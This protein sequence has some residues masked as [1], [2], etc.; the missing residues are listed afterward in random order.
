MGLVDRLDALDQR[1]L[2]ILRVPRLA[3]WIR[4]HP[5]ATLGIFVASGYSP[6]V[7]RALP[8]ASWLGAVSSV[9]LLLGLLWLVAAAI[10][11]VHDMNDRGLRGWVW[12]A[13]VLLTNVVGLLAWIIVRQDVQSR[14]DANSG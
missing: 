8:E 13:L 4:R 1:A 5:V 7:A 12:G 10:A 2:A 6:L 11:A 9:S 14:S 3:G